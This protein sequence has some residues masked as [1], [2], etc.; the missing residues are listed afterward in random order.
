MS[1]KLLNDQ[2]NRQRADSEEDDHG[3]PD[4]DGPHRRQPSP[5]QAEQ[6]FYELMKAGFTAAVRTGSGQISQIRSFDPTAEET[7]FFPKL[8]GG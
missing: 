2:R 6:R 5:L 7:L 8:V 1:T 3:D 4:R